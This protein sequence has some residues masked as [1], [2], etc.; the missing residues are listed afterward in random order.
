M[1]DDSYELLIIGAGP[2]GMAAACEA[3][4]HG[5]RVAVLDNQTSPGGQI[6]RN[7][8]RATDSQNR[9]LGKDYVKGRSLVDRFKQCG[10]SYFSEATV[11]FLD[12]KR[13]VGVLI[14]DKSYFVSADKLVLATGAQERPMPIKGWQLPGVMS[15]GAGQILL[16]SA[17]MVPEGRLVLAGTGPLILL[18]AYQYLQAGVKIDA[19]IDTT[20][21]GAMLRS[22]GKLFKALP[23]VDYLLKGLKMMLAVRQ[24]GIPVYHGVEGLGAVG[25]EKLEAVRFDV[26]KAGLKKVTDCELQADT[27]L[28]HQGV[29]P[30]IRLPLAAGCEIEWDAQQQNW[31]VATDEWG[32]SS[33]ADIY[34]VGDG[35]R[36]AGAEASALQGR[37]AGM[38][39]SLQL[40]K[41]NAGKLEALSGPVVKS[42]K[43]H[44][45]IRPFLDSCYTPSPR[46]LVPDDT[47]LVCRCEEISAGEIRQAV[48]LG[49]T[50][51]NQVKSFT[52]CGM[53]PCQ[54][55]QCSST[56]SLIISEQ[57]GKPMTE[58]GCIRV[59]PPLSPITLGQLSEV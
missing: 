23:A 33:D 3:T 37:L 6:Y 9:I 42:Y 44:L 7:V 52:R 56:V 24:A 48:R 35:S 8:D 36:I 27:L 51:P 57:L 15:A 40:G 5:V 49:C 59:R 54:G 29:I 41:I 25:E 58:V 20:P 4:S 16:K 39:V 2:A 10:G 34:V 18:L 43:R 19:L 50:G 38:H 12:E 17:G 47:T 26:G 22:L 30:N 45:S 32:R 14:D 21:Q 31:I 53:G 28:L 55:G 11:W 13:R 1:I 46:Y